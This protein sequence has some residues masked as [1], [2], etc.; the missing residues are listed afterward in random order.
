MRTLAAAA[1]IAFALVVGCKGKATD[2]TRPVENEA[3]S[4][5]ECE[6]RPE[7]TTWY[8][9]YEKLQTRKAGEHPAEHQ[10][11]VREHE[12]LGQALARKS[13]CDELADAW[14]AFVVWDRLPG[15]E[16]KNACNRS[17]TTSDLQRS[18]GSCPCLSR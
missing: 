5:G 7:W 15:F 9:G 12:K 17:Q 2:E 11:R 1:V 6:N 14:Q 13:G 10:K 16:S 18:M 8:E 4:Q 3:S